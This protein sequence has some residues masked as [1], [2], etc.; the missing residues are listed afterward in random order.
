MVPEV[1]G[2]D[3]RRAVIGGERTEVDDTLS[4]REGETGRPL[5]HA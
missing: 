3:T 2:V 4:G 5:S 1:K